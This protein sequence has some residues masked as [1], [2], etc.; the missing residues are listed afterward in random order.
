MNG[1][2]APIIVTALFGKADFAYLNGLRRQYYPAERNLVD[3][4]LTFF[5]HLPPSASEDLNT[6]LSAETR[7]VEA[8]EARLTNVMSLGTGVAFGVY[9]PELGAMRERMAD[10]FMGLLI[11]VDQ[12]PWNPHVTIQ[13][14][15]IPAE[16]DQ[17]RE[18]L[19]QSFKPRRLEITGLACWHYRNGPWEALSTHRFAR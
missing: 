15:V 10:A 11:P 16:A 18:E 3:A 4:H 9:S 13:N 1:S 14:K 2:P 6:R 19:L 17:L 8:P 5:Q 12:R 7:G